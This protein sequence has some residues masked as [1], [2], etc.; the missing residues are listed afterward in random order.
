M[1][2]SAEPMIKL[3]EIPDKKA[4]GIPVLSYNVPE[5]TS[6]TG[7]NFLEMDFLEKGEKSEDYFKTECFK[8]KDSTT[9]SS[10]RIGFIEGIK[11]VFS[12]KNR[13]NNYLIRN[14]NTTM[15]SLKVNVNSPQIAHNLNKGNRLILYRN[16]YGEQTYTIAPKPPAIRPRIVLIE[17]NRLSTY[18]GAYGAGKTLKTFSLL[19]GEKTRISIKTYHRTEELS[20]QASS[21]LD[22]FTK[23]SSADFE[24]SVASEN[25]FKQNKSENFE[26]HAEAEA[27]ASWGFGK[28][29]V[30]GGVKGGTNS[31]REEFAKNIQSA[32]S[33]H[34]NKASAKRDVQ[35]NTSSEVKT[36]SGEE[37]EIVREIENI[38]VSRTL[39]F[40][41]RQMNQEFITIHHLTDIRLGFFNG[42]PKAKAEYTLPELDSMLEEYIKPEKIAAVK[43]AILNQILEIRDFKDNQPFGLTELG[44]KPKDKDGNETDQYF[45]REKHYKKLD[46]ANNIVEV[47]P[48]YYQFAKDLYSKFTDHN[49]REILV[50]GIILSVNKNVLRT[51]GV[52]VDS[53]LGQGD[54]L[55]SYSKSLQKED[56]QTKSLNNDKQRIENEKGDLALSIIRDKC[57]EKAKIYSELFPSQLCLPGQN[58]GSS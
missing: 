56:I 8:T 49:E 46:D 35:V 50:P 33:K 16:M 42:D 36:E 20:K 29:K 44:E 31:S 52:I 6:Y 23:E 43:T 4:G 57:T 54:A 2:N 19:P 26:Y 22:S 14:H 12:Q 39:N 28:A 15:D 18:S 17:T 40:V 10:S 45:I 58:Q 24:S 13:I 53:I 7:L 30:S 55:D 21:I 1:A 48:C 5:P 3:G 51:D 27:S 32:T 37:T 41:F 25:S 9:T 11:S 47:E 38:N 34:A